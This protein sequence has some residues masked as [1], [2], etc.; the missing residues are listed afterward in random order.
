MARLWFGIFRIVRI[1]YLRTLAAKSPPMRTD[2][3]RNSQIKMQERRSKTIKRN[4]GRSKEIK[5]M[6]N[7]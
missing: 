6:G 1:A 7:A 4:R 3:I 5:N 2:I